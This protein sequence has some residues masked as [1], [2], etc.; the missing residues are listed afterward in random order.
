[1]TNNNNNNQNPENNPRVSEGSIF[2]PSFDIVGNREVVPHINGWKRLL[3]IP[4]N[5]VQAICKFVCYVLAASIYIEV[6]VLFP[7]IFFGFTIFWVVMTIA[8]IALVYKD[9]GYII[10]VVYVL[11][12]I[13]IGSLL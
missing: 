10:D 1:M 13:L 7:P 8:M 9:N 12:A 4:S 5:S 3:G 11:L 2:R 6:Y